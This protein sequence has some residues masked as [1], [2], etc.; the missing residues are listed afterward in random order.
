MRRQLRRRMYDTTN[1]GQRKVAVRFESMTRRHVATSI[2]ESGS[3]TQ[4]PTLLTGMSSRP[5][6][7]AAVSTTRRHSAARVKSAR[8]ANARRPSLSID[9]TARRAAARPFDSQ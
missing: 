3:T 9:V 4:P 7:R 5:S 2:D 1:L 8:T 6:F